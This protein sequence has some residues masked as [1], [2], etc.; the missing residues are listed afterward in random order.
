M[1]TCAPYV[2]VPA[3]PGVVL[4]PALGW[5]AIKTDGV[6]GGFPDGLLGHLTIIA[7]VTSLAVWW[8][9]R[10]GSRRLIRRYRDRCGSPCPNPAR[11]EL[12][13]PPERVYA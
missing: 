6:A 4:S 5:W 12:E 13:R 8:P 7:C 2:V 3:V 11:A 1:L 10:A 9:G